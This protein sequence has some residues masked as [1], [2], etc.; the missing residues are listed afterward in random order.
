MTNDVLSQTKVPAIGL[1]VIG[2]LNGLSGLLMLISGL[3]RLIGKVDDQ[4]PTDEAGRLGYYMGTGFGYGIGFF[5][6]ILAPLIIYGALSMLKGQKPGLAKTA[7]ILAMLPLSSCCFVLGIPFGI[8]ALIVLRKP[9][10]KA[11]FENQA[12]NQFNPPQPPQW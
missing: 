6:L 4:I 7:A 10:V 9:E 3:L 12:N 2:S 1:L 11:V 5:S 8:W